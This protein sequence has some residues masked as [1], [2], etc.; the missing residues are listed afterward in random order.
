MPCLTSPPTIG[1]LASGGVDSCVLTAH[2]LRQGYCVCPF[3]V[4]GG[5]AWER[6]ELAALRA[7]LKAVATARLR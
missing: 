5:L 6:E 1:V 4:R 2:L 3:Y 7:F